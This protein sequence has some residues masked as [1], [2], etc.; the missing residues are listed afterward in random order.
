MG[1]NLQVWEL[2]SVAVL[3]LSEMMMN[4]G[5]E[6]ENALLVLIQHP[7]LSKWYFFSFLDAEYLQ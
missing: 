2:G 3:G 4:A 5:T 7:M 6:I 1:Q